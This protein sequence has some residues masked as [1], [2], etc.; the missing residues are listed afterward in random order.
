MKLLI[1]TQKVDSADGLLG[2]FHDWLKEFA[3]VFSE[4]TVICLFEGQHELPGNVRVLSLG[5]ENG[6]GRVSYLFNFYRYLW[7][8]RKNYDVVFVH[9]NA[10]YVI[11]GGWIWRWAGK[12]IGLWYTHKAVTWKLRLAE[13]SSDVIFTASPESFQLPSKKIVIVGHGIDVNKFSLKNPAM[14]KPDKFRIV[15]VGRISEI[16]NLLLLVRAI[17]LLV[18]E[19]GLDNLTVSLIGE[20]PNSRGREYAALLKE[21]IKKLRLEKY[22]DWVG[23]VPNR[24]LPA[25]YQQADLS[26][27]LCPT[28]GLD[29][30][31]LESMA[32]GVPALVYNKTFR[33]IFGGYQEQLIISQDDQKEVAEKIQQ[34]LALKIEAK[35]NLSRNLR[36]IVVS[37][38]SVRGLIGKIFKS[39]ED[40]E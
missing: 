3:E 22:I 15:S 26:V 5:K 4:V 11:L 34:L 27:N 21:E 13:L 33:E 17:D 25:F 16:K 14:T 8:E 6:A 36:Q 37:N 12:K 10:E 2:F 1:I 23:N 24:D 30:A 20:P 35:N 31:V 28:G 9:M 7:Q 19:F 40:Q 29:K 32:C 38:Y 18:H 39:Y